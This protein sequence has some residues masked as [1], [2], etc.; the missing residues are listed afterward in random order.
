MIMKM[1]SSYEGGDDELVLMIVIVI[2][3]LIMKVRNIRRLVMEVVM[4]VQP[5]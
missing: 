2:K 4:I 5:A 1:V 3:W